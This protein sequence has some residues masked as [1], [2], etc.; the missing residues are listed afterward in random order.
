M[1]FGALPYTWFYFHFGKITDKKRQHYHLL[2]QRCNRWALSIIPGLHFTAVNKVGE[3]FEKPAVIICNH[4]S[5]LDILAVLQ[6]SP[7]MVIVTNGWTWN[8]PFY[9]SVLH[10]GDFLPAADGIDKNMHKL[11]ELYQQG[12]SIVIYPE[13]TRSTD[14]EIMRFHKGAF[15][16]AH[17]L[18][19]DILPLYLHGAGYVLPKK[20][21]MLREGDVRIEV[22]ERVRFERYDDIGLE[23]NEA[24]RKMALDMRH[25]YQRKYAEICKEVETDDYLTPYRKLRDYYQM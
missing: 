24:I 22:G 17:E 7:K 8:N 6:F 19:A 4:Q 25:Q 1:Y 12:Y 20:D 10:H 9:G 18:G 5:H 15:Y 11:C 2:I 14:C 16:L 23:A 3:T 13:A 21:F